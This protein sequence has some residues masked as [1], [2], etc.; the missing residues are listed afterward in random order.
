MTLWFYVDVCTSVMLFDFK[1]ALFCLFH[2]RV[3]GIFA[4]MYT[5]VELRYLVT[6]LN[7]YII[8]SDEATFSKI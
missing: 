2:V 4:S 6:I 8:F 5:S 7:V 1:S 3:C